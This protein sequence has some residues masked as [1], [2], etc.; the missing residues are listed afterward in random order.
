MTEN[1]KI[2]MTLQQNVLE[3]KI[4]IAKLVE[5]CNNLKDEI[6]ILKDKGVGTGVFLDGVPE[7][8]RKQIEQEL[9]SGKR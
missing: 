9:G 5:L 8:Y 2:V 7:I 6:N 4:D 1:E 3:L